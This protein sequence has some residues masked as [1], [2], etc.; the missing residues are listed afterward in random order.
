[1]RKDADCVHHEGFY[2]FD[3]LVHRVMILLEFGDDGEASV[4]WI[5]NHQDYERIFKNN[6]KTIE[7]RLKEN[8]YI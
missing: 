5:G 7:K 4:V 1:M 3:I 2:L 6:K 8:D